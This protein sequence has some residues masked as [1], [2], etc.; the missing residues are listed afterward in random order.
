MVTMPKRK[1]FALIYPP[2]IK[3]HLKSIEAKHY[4]FIRESLENQLQFEPDVETRNRKP[5]KRPVVFGAKWEIRFGAD[6]R[7]RVFYRIE[8][9]RQQVVILAIGE[10]IGNRLCIGGEEIEL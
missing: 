10:K 5:L 2:I 6:N 1:R 7:F 4:S 9:D 8:Y 3:Q